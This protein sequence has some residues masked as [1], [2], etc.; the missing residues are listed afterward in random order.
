MSLICGYETVIRGSSPFCG[1][2]VLSINEWLGFE[3]TNDVRYFYNCGYGAPMSGAIG[4]PWLK[5]SFNALMSKHNSYSNE[6][7]DQDM[8]V[9]FTHR[10]MPPMVIVALGLFNNSAYSGANDI[11]STM[12]LN[13]INHQR[14]WKSSNIIPFLTDI[15]IEKL[16]CDS[17]GFE[18][19]TYYRVMVNGN[20]HSLPDCNDG[21]GESCKES[22]T[23]KWL[24]ERGKI[25]GDFDTKC[26]LNNENITH[27]LN[28]YN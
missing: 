20:P 24:A 15:G 5:A 12:P 4:F 1:L 16:D 21:P 11:L 9:S 8:F 23:V 13:T 2:S 3:Y 18:K 14:V 19:G 10:S 26:M 25:V 17:Y 6:T 22:T 7:A 27:Q 28:L